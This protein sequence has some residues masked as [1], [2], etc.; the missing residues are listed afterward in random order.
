MRQNHLSKQQPLLQTLNHHLP[1]NMFLI[2]DYE[3]ERRANPE[4]QGPLT[5]SSVFP[6]GNVDENLDYILHLL[7]VTTMV[8]Q[9][10]ILKEKLGLELDLK[11]TQESQG[12]WGPPGSHPANPVAG[13]PG[14]WR[15]QRQ[16]FSQS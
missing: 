13:A 5:T 8:E 10:P 7:P 14:S 4:S 15:W 9:Y 11:G 16:T 12:P 2:P 6:L 1:V 3:I